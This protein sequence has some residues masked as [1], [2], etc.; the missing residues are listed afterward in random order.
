MASPIGKEQTSS[1]TNHVYPI[2]CHLGPFISI[3]LVSRASR[4]FCNP[5]ALRNLKSQCDVD[6]RGVCTPANPGTIHRGLCAGCSCSMPSAGLF[7]EFPQAPKHARCFPSCSSDTLDGT[8]KVWQTVPS[9]WLPGCMGKITS[10]Q[11]SS[12]SSICKWACYAHGPEIYLTGVYVF[13]H[14]NTVLRYIAVALF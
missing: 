3:R 11:R 6:S 14:A 5:A 2:G 8:N 7:I 4:F 9:T 13:Q 12:Q 1:W 10:P